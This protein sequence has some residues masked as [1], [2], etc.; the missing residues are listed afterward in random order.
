MFR[1]D[2]GGA[3]RRAEGSSKRPS[4]G[5]AGTK[6]RLTCAEHREPDMIQLDGGGAICRGEGCTKRPSKGVA[7]TKMQ[8]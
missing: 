7:G 5:V 8:A 6:T 3:I 1:L 2:G 4:Y